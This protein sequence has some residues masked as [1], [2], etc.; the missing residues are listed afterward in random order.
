MPI[1]IMH[2]PV[3]CE[4]ELMIDDVSISSSRSWLLA[5][6]TSKRRARFRWRRLEM[7]I[8]RNSV[9]HGDELIKQCGHLRQK[10]FSH[11][12]DLWISKCINVVPSKSRRANDR[13]S[14]IHRA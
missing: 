12:F 1:S 9:G 5:G 3:A 14:R 10:P 6:L 4:I 13:I 11:A 2:S 8:A 7:T